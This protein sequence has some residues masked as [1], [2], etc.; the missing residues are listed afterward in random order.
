M[1]YDA[2]VIGGGPGGATTA[3]LLAR[4]GWRVAVVEKAEF[5]RSKVC[6]EFIS[7][8]SLPLLRKLGVE[9]AFLAAA[10]PMV[11]RVGLLAKDD[12]L[13]AAMPER[14]DWIG[15]WG[16]ALGREQ[17][18]TLLLEA[19]AREGAT[20]WQPWKIAELRRDHGS[21]MCAAN[22]KNA[23]VELAA[24]VVIAA[25]GSWERGPLP[26]PQSRAHRPS[27]LLAFKAHFRDCDLPADLMP[28]LVFPGGYGGMVHSD[29]GRV[30][31]SCCIRRDA[32]LR[33]RERYGERHAATAVLRHIE[34]SC[35]GVRDALQR[36]TLDGPW[37]SAGP[38]Q[39]G[40]RQRYADG[41][42]AVGNAAGE[43]HP[44]V[45]EGISMA[46]QSAGLL[47]GHLIARQNDV[48]AGDGL[49]TV[50]MHYDAD[51]RAGFSARIQAAAVFAHLAMRPAS[52]ATLLP[53]LKL[54]PRVL[55]LGARLSG[56]S[57]EVVAAP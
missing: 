24:R 30:S 10:G 33:A 52:V 16:R 9:D 4:A 46:L 14:S 18:D 6:G 41:V 22:T 57:T 31:L 44:I 51:W 36:A 26:M 23:T 1:R 49:R 34:A 27:D 29:G 28:L 56:K 25:N 11:R 38:I 21:S 17:L 5:P 45:A 7:A 13:T 15:R 43:A 42:F 37:L 54:F 39:P 8:S 48:F 47:A 19:A 20:L 2:L 53:V 32:L 55:T 35:A 40:M 3:L 50:A 12:V